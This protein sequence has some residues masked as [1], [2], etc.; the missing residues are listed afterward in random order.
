MEM[1]RLNYIPRQSFAATSHSDKIHR[2]S[3]IAPGPRLLRTIV[4]ATT[5][6]GEETPSIDFAFIGS[7]LLPDGNPDVAFRSATGGRKLRNIMKDCHIDLYGPY[8]KA[9]LNCAGGGT[10][11]T[12]IVEVVAGKELLSPRTD[13]EKE[14]L[15]KKPKNWRLA[16][17]TVVGKEDSRGEVVIQ[18]LPEWKVHEWD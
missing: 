7:R 8:D 4:R 11:G 10:C 5:D 15:E 18:T 13:K 9:L 14:I 17:Q 2:A 12:C 3:K 16:C 1:L 6:P